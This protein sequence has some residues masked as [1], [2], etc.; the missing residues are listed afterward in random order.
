MGVQRQ[1]L[2]HYH[3]LGHHSKKS[4]DCTLEPGLSGHSERCFSNLDV[5][6]KYLEVLLKC[7]F[8]L[9]KSQVGP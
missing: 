4:E 1:V 9:S 3:V 6:T 7:R 5:L 8:S 2:S